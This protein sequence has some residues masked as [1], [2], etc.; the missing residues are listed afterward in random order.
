ML[1]IKDKNFFKSK[2]LGTKHK[3]SSTYLHQKDGLIPSKE[4]NI[5]D[6]TCSRKILAKKLDKGQPIARERKEKDR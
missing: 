3:T 5:S 4:D 2:F 6:S 1:F